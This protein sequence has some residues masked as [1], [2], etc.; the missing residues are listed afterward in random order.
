[1]FVF[2]SFPWAMVQKMQALAAMIVALTGPLYARGQLEKDSKHLL[3]HLSQVF[4]RHLATWVKT[5]PVLLESR[6]CVHCAARLQPAKKILPQN[7]VLQS[8]SQPPNL[9]ILLDDCESFLC[10]NDTFKCPS[11]YCIK[12][13]YVCDGLWD[14]PSGHDETS[15]KSSSPG[16]YKC[17]DT[18]IHVALENIC[19]NFTDCPFSDDQMLCDIRYVT[20][21]ENCSC[22]LRYAIT[23]SKKSCCKWY[24]N[25][26]RIH[27]GKHP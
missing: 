3:C 12:L 18:Q 5:T 20:C 2:S 13:R 19:D 4:S 14:C 24:T 7:Q 15:C 6:F 11:L 8:W 9:S 26:Q 21:P 17:K 16:L 23:R 25:V 22:L 27:P 10:P 1:M